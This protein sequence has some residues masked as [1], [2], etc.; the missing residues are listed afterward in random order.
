MELKDP[1]SSTLDTSDSDGGGGAAVM[2][3]DGIKRLRTQAGH[4]GAVA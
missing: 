1:G 3:K 4:E 2:A